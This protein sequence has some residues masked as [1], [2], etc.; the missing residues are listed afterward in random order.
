MF[1]EYKNLSE[2]ELDTKMGDVS[3]K[4]AMAHSM[5]LDGVVEQL[6]NILENLH[7]EL[8]TRL[9]QQRFDIINGRIPESLIVGE[10]DEHA[11]DSDT[12]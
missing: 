7:M 5:G 6:Q 2:E 1:Q 3:K 11:D 9:D 4:I 12:D 8:T 10:D